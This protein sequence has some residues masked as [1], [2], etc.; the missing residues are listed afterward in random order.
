MMRKIPDIMQAAVIDGWGGIEALGPDDRA[1]PLDQI[2]EA[3]RALEAHYI[4]KLAL[5][6]HGAPDGL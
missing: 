2:A 1:F 3:H 6:P 4:G 5:R